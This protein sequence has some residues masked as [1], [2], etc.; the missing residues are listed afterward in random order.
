MKLTLHVA[1]T[2]I[3]GPG[4][5][6]QIERPDKGGTPQKEDPPDITSARGKLFLQRGRS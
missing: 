5:T 2:Q 1:V 4:R 6:A 3:E